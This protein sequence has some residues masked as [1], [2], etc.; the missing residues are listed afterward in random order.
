MAMGYAQL[1][2]KKRSLEQKKDLHRD[3]VVNKEHHSANSSKTKLKEHTCKMI[4]GDNKVLALEN[5]SS[6]K[7]WV[8]AGRVKEEVRDQSMERKCQKGGAKEDAKDCGGMMRTPLLTTNDLQ[9]SALMSQLK[10]ILS[11]LPTRHPPNAKSALLSFAH[12]DSWLMY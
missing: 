2:V 5:K 4:D 10:T 9:T 12:T 7:L 6:P 1:H 3:R 8:D 11:V